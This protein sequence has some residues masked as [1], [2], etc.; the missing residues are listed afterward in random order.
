[1]DIPTLDAIFAVALILLIISIISAAYV[2]ARRQKAINARIHKLMNEVKRLLGDRCGPARLIC[3]LNENRHP[4]QKLET[5]R[6]LLDKILSI[7]STYPMALHYY[8]LYHIET[9]H[10]DL[11]EKK[12]AMAARTAAAGPLPR[13]HLGNFY[14]ERKEYALAASHYQ[15]AIQIDPNLDLPY[16]GLGNIKFLQGKICSAMVSY[17][18]AAGLNQNNADALI[19]LGNC[20]KDNNNTEKAALCYEQ[21]YRLDRTNKG[22]NAVLA[23][24]YI[25]K[26]QY[27]RAN[28]IMTGAVGLDPDSSSFHKQLGDINSVMNKEAEAVEAYT[29]FLRLTCENEILTQFIK[30]KFENYLAVE[31]ISDLLRKQKKIN[32]HQFIKEMNNAVMIYLIR[33]R[34]LG[35]LTTT[36]KKAIQQFSKFYIDKVVVSIAENK[37]WR[38]PQTAGHAVLAS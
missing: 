24:V 4:R 9:G 18:K 5:A 37:N 20:Y 12:L 10:L 36:K 8:A 23:E 13:Y 3:D 32:Y 15:R 27:H 11:A 31:I 33:K 38:P 34:T 21:A 22:L 25:A 17:S 2:R 28:E 19:G 29:N 1:M 30:S 6:R 26:K 14:F 16:I 7:R 35:K